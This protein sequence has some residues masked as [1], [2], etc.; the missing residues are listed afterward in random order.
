MDSGLGA[1]ALG[2]LFG[3]QHATDADHVVAV[4]SIVSRTGRFAA[5]VLVGAFWGLGH[6]VTIAVAGMAIVVF[7]VTVTPRAGLSMELLVAVMLMALGVA[8]IARLMRGRQ[9]TLTLLS[10]GH[11]HGAPGVWR[12][13]RTLG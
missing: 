4:A 8:R 12:V 6:S 13:L 10:R 1:I 3:L 2:F 5:G 7:N 9:E 11:G